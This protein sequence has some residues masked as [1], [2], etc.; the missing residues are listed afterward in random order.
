MRKLAI[1]I[2]IIALGS[3]SAAQAEDCEDLRNEVIAVAI[4]AFHNDTNNQR[5][6]AALEAF[7]KSG[8]SCDR[9]TQEQIS[10]IFEDLKS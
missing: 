6:E 10:K 4:A 3:T 8:P 7:Q 1:I 2:M 9:S 5:T